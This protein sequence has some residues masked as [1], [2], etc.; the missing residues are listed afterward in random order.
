MQIIVPEEAPQIP[1]TH[2]KR[3]SV[4]SHVLCP[5]RKQNHVQIK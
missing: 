1:L 3:I 2:A 4:I 5:G